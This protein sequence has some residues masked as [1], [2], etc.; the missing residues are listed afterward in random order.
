MKECNRCKNQITEANVW[1][2]DAVRL[3]PG[4]TDCTMCA[5]IYDNAPPELC[6]VTFPATGP[7]TGVLPADRFHECTKVDQMVAT[8]VPYAPG[9]PR[10]RICLCAAQWH[11]QFGWWWWYLLIILNT[12]STVRMVVVV[13]PHH[14]PPRH[15][16][17]G[18]WWW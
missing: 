13:A 15:Q 10:Q 9:T 7:S 11:Q 4:A 18:W 8:A 6:T 5:C 2:I 17:F 12:A 14:H 1:G 3:Q 16:Q